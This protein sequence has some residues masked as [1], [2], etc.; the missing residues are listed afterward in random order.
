ME[1]QLPVSDPGPAGGAPG[2]RGPFRRRQGPGTAPIRL[3]RRDQV[4]RPGQGDAWALRLR[5]DFPL[6]SRR[7]AGRRIVYLDSAATSQKSDGAI[8]A[9]SAFCRSHNAGDG[10]LRLEDLDAELA[11]GRVRL[12]AV[13]HV[14]NVLGTINPV[15]EIV[16]RARA[17]GATA[18]VDGSQAVP[19]LPVDGQE[20]GADFYAWTGHKALGPTGFGVLHGRRELLEE[21]SPFLAGGDMISAV[22]LHDVTARL[23]HWGSLQTHSVA[24]IRQPCAVLHLEAVRSALAHDLASER[25]DRS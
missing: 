7:I 25:D 5:R 6:L 2:R 14:S 15:T 23:G 8:D 20:T 3:G 12:A 17:A 16:R 4:P 9:M 19:H 11:S 22:D 18:L 24:S 1:L 21:M 13:A 10:L